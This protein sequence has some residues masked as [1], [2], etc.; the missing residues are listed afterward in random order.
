[1]KFF[2]RVHIHIPNARGKFW[3]KSRFVLGYRNKNKF[4]TMYKRKEVPFLS[5][6]SLF[7]ISQNKKYFFFRFVP[8]LRNVCLYSRI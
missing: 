1:M 4:L 5:E 6:I 2:L 8:G 3:Y 7:C